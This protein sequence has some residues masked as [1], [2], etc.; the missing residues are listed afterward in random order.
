MRLEGCKV[1]RE[2]R[3]K[4]QDTRVKSYELRVMDFAA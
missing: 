1:K 2:V 3:C 4:T